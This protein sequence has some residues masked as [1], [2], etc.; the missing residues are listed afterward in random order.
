MFNYLNDGL[1]ADN[2]NRKDVSKDRNKW[3]REKIL[4]IREP[5]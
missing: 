3:A 2:V 4:S 1:I 5:W